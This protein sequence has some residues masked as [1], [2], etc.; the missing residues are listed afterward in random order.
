M[1]FRPTRTRLRHAG[2]AL[3]VAG[4]TG[5]LAIAAPAVSSAARSTVPETGAAPANGTVSVIGLRE[6][7]TGAGV[8]AVQERLISFGYVIRSG[9]DG[10]FGPS[11]TRVLRRFQEQNGLNPTGVVTENTARYLGFAGGVAAPSN[12]GSSDSVTTTPP[13]TSSGGSSAGASTGGSFVGLSRGATGDAVRQLQQTLM[14]PPIGLYLSSGADGVF[15]PSTE[16]AVKLVQRVNGLPE[17]G[18]VTERVAQILG[19]TASASPAA[20]APAAGTVL[21]YGSQ[22]AAV[23]RIQQ[24]LMNAGIHVAGG[25]D[26]IFGLATQRAVREFQQARGLPVTGKVDAST[27]TALAGATGGGSSSSGGS[28]NQSNQ[29]VGLRL[30]STGAGVRQVQQAI[31]ATGMYLRGGAD[32]I[33]GQA[34][35]SALVK[36]QQTNG[37]A[38]TGVVDAATAR[39]MGLGTST[40]GGGSGLSGGGSTAAGY[41]VYDERGAR[42]RALQSALIS[43]G[44]SVP[45]GADGVFGSGTLGAVRAFQQARGL[46]TTGKVDQAT[47][48]ALGL[49]PMDAPAAEQPVTI[50]LQARPVAG[51]CWYGDTWQASRGGG[52]RHLGVDIGAAEGT[53][54]RAVA[55]GRITYVYHDRPGSLS[56]NALKITTADGTYFFY[57]HMAG[58]ADGIEVGVPVQAGQIIGYVGKTGNAAIAHL[59]LEIHPRGGSAVNPYPIIKSFGAC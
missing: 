58:F 2:L 8:R 53:P 45:G 17:T 24:L 47:G 37:I 10:V 41:A 7:A 19:L 43:A 29:Y 22:G 39:L 48:A 42:V 21:Q 28:T 34:T 20:P 33:F 4:L 55:N 15:G 46:P 5:G 23:K 50:A 51:T 40:S 32:G 6:G 31:I 18:V 1:T 3:V 56:G 49:A 27:E 26:G 14:A 35:H 52:R 25:A 54:L 9:P 44:V 30:G 36:Y 57:A 38:A 12:G 11:T 16:H 59:H 13:P